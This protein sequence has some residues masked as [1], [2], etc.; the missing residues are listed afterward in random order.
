MSEIRVRGSLPGWSVLLDCILGVFVASVLMKSC[1]APPT[2]LEATGM[3]ARVWVDEVR[4][5]YAVPPR[6]EAPNE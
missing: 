2:F 1:S 5:G 3:T 6:T 4:A